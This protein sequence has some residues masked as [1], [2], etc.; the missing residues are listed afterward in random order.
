MKYSPDLAIIHCKTNNHRSKLSGLEIATN[1]IKLVSN[2]K[3]AQNE[4]VIWS[5]IYRGEGFNNKVFKVNANLSTMVGK[6]QLGFL[7]NS[8]IGSEHLQ[9]VDINLNK[10]EN[11]F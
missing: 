9:G 7:D 6:H 10:N 4:F 3:Y 5:L 1:I 11:D 8:N 2:M